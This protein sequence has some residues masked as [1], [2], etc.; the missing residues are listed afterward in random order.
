MSGQRYSVGGAPR[1]PRDRGRDRGSN[2]S[3]AAFLVGVA[4]IAGMIGYALQK[5]TADDSA[6]TGVATSTASPSAATPSQLTGLT[7]EQVA[8]RLAGA[9]VPLQTKVV[10]S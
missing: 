5:I 2:G 4:I 9:G 6:S 8:I 7:A 3:M 1:P 10:Y